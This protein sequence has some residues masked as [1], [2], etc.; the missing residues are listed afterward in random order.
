MKLSE[1]I[2]TG[3]KIRPQAFGSLEETEVI[4]EKVGWFKRRFRREKRTCALGA[5]FEAT[6]ARTETRIVPAGYITSPFRGQ[7]VT[8]EQE[9]AINV[10]VHPAEWN[11]IYYYQSECPQ[12]EKPD[13]V[14][15]LIVHLNDDHK[16]KREEIALWVA[17]MEEVAE[18]AQRITELNE[19]E[20]AA[21]W[22]N[23][24]NV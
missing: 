2:R 22:P 11:A 9:A 20:N 4:T 15:S 5:A 23:E 21:E 10:V 7:S 1:A 16:W 8:L 14:N 6:G 3:A 24:I 19:L 12:C 18:M 13:E 17:R